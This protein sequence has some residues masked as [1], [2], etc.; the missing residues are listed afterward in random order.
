MPCRPFAFVVVLAALGPAS[1]DAAA[2]PRGPRGD[3]AWTP[4]PVQDGEPWQRE[5][6]KHWVDAR[7]RAMD[8]GPFLNATIDYTA[9]RGS[10]RVYKATAICVGDKGEAAVLFD[11]NQLRLAAGWTGGYLRH[12][13]T[14][15]GLLNTPT[16]AGPLAFSSRQ[17]P[18]W[19]GPK[20]SWDNKHPPTAP[21]PRE[22][23]KFRG[24]YLH[25][26]RVVLSY[27]V[28]GV[29]VLDS[30]WAETAGGHTVFSRT[31]EVGPS[32][33]EL[34]MLVCECASPAE[35]VVKL[36]GADK[37]V[38]V[39]RASPTRVEVHFKPAATARRAKVVIG[40]G[41]AINAAINSGPA[42]DLR[43]LTRPGPPRWTKPIVTRGEVAAD[44][45]PHVIDTFTVPY[46]NPHKALM[47][48]SGLD[49][50]PNGNV[51]VCTAH[52]D[53]WLVQGAGTSLDKLT[54]KRFA[55]GLYQPLGLRVVDGKI[56]VLERGQLTRLH[57]HNGAGEAD[58][59]ENFNNDWHTG[60]GEHSFDTCLETDPAGNFYFFKTGDP[61][62]PSG[63]CLLRVAKDGSKAD[64]FATGFRHPIGLSVGP[65]GTVTGADQE[66]NWMPA[67]RIDVYRRGGF[68]GFMPAHHRKRPPASYDRPLLWLPKLADNS[69][70][71]QV[72]VAGDRFGLPAG[73]L[74]HLSY[75]RCKLFAVL[76]QQI[77]GVQQAGAVDL[78][79]FFLSGIMR[80]RFNSRDGHL[81]VCGLRGWQTAARR[82]GC[83][84]RVRYTGRPL[85]LP[86]TLAVHADGI[87]VRFTQKLDPKSARDRARYR[88][89]CWN[90]RYSG[91]YGSKHWSAARP[92]REG[93]DVLPVD[94]AEPSADGRGVF[95]R[96]RGL[97]PVMQMKIGYDLKTADGKS[98]AGTIYNTV[99][100]TAPAA[101]R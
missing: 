4:P 25:G 41:T 38:S 99:H 65:D 52:G 78:G 58:F 69:A 60:G 14:R 26:R 55:T 49:F 11:R 45:K 90:Y 8:T 54:W 75:G 82:D 92:H 68:Y 5:T 9:P 33:H 35:P 98:L 20:N 50:L 70:G 59:Y 97:G 12:K 34:R 80:G 87:A 22:W 44:G 30:P 10:V 72:W 53:V 13:D 83:L 101:K 48:L 28:G 19:A 42:P 21:L 85:L 88:L 67:T 77:G 91:S 23:A 64:V 63:G 57:D 24:L 1:A 51:A 17:G 73:Q 2:P 94:A 62:T 74:L 86:N 43:A 46:D 61:E 95:L 76:R 29:D 84:Q 36:I 71:G 37:G 31:I 6:D 15:F 81:Y 7:F 40:N 16:P 3:P 100:R 18:G 39:H 47:F 66:G 93:H 27:S 79:L 56:I 32:K 89:E 96:V